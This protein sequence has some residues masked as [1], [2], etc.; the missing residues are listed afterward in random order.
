LLD[1]VGDVEGFENKIS[2]N[3]LKYKAQVL[4]QPYD[5]ACLGYDIV[6]NKSF[7]YSTK[8]FKAAV[9]DLR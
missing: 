7:S 3:G 5:K 1:A 9:K 2:L 6:N 4:F 8:V